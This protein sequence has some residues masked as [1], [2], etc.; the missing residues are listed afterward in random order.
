MQTQR[1]RFSL[2]SAIFA[3]LAVTTA[4]ITILGLW[5]EDSVFGEV[6]D[7]LLQVVA[8]TV[9]LAVIL[10]IWNLL[11]VHLGR[12]TKGK[13]G[14]GYSLIT[15]LTALVVIIVQILD[16]IDVWTGDLAGEKL[17]PFLFKTLEVSIE[18]ALAGLI[19]FF[20]IFAAYRL[21]SRRAQWS[22]YL[23]VL[24]VLIGLLGWVQL[25]DITLFADINNW[26]MNVPVLAGSRGLLIGIGLASIIVGVRTLTGTDQAYRE[27]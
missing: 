22:S 24:T 3:T 17:S 20:L 10:G 1:R 9:V 26:V 19:G 4:L 15:L 16:E 6:V 12:L 2:L 27:D 18:A 5:L 7:N 21:L 8:V 14:W 13:G 11:T 23:F 25:A